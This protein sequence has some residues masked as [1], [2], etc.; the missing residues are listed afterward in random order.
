MKNEFAVD[1]TDLNPGIWFY[2]NESEPEKGG[3]CVRP[4]DSD[5]L[6]AINKETVTKKMVYKRGKRY[7]AQDVDSEKNQEM[8]IDRTLPDWKVFGKDG[9]EIPCTLENKL[10]LIRQSPW[11]QHFYTDC[12]ATAGD[13]EN[14]SQRQA[15]K[16]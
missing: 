13:L 2:F 16:N 12:L 8:M 14:T 5:A 6:A 15:A 9:A 4:L 7:E 3:F 1:L 10:T 11:H